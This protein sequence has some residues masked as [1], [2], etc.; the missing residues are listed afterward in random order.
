MCG[1]TGWFALKASSK[2][3]LIKMTEALSHRGPNAS[4][5]YIDDKVAL[6][7]RR[8]SVIDV[9]LSHQ[10]MSSLD[11]RYHLAYNGEIYNFQAL[12][13]ELEALGYSFQTKGDTEV[14]FNALI[15]WKLD[16]LKKLQGMFAFAFWDKKDEHL[17]LARDP[18]GIKPLHYFWDGTSLVFASELKS[19]LKHQAC[20]KDI[21]LQALGLFL[22]CQYIPAPYTIYKDIKKLEQGSYLSLKKGKLEKMRF[23]S[24]DYSPKVVLSENELV[25]T[26]DQKLN[27]IVSSMLVADVPYG[28]FVSGGIDSSLV[29]ALMNKQSAHKVPL[30]TIGFS[31]NESHD[32]HRYAKRVA[33][34]LDCPH[35]VLMLT[36]DAS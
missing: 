12:R 24:V 34:H 5:Y 25:D 9:A 22:E 32:E 21:D 13:K 4:G 28:A 20:S 23:F 36:F 27:E 26:L 6:G 3:E 11:E 35:H 8:L 1:F 31:G 16:A 18:L 14:L 17:I 29:A 2:D 33:A 19:I 15:E 7:H 10:P 30:F